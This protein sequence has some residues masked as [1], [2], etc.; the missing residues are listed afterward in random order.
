MAFM[1]T[2]VANADD[3]DAWYAEEDTELQTKTDPG[4]V[5]SDCIQR[6]SAYLGEKTTLTTLSGL[7]K[8]AIESN[9]WKEKCMGLNFLGMISDTCKKQFKSNVDEVA[10]MAVSGLSH[11]NPRV[12]FEAMQCLGL[13]LH[14]LAP[15][16]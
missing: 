12:R 14:D 11:E 5:A 15:T 3:I 4:S 9:E 1:G 2:E 16:F 7:I 10:K 6:M 13:L 8:A